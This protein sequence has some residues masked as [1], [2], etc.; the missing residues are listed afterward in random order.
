MHES[1]RSRAGDTV[2]MLSWSSRAAFDADDCSLSRRPRIALRRRT[3]G[4]G[5]PAARCLLLIPL[6]QYPRPH[7]ALAPSTPSYGLSQLVH[8]PRTQGDFD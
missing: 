7:R 8:D 2:G 6:S 4:A 5:T 3:G 1:G